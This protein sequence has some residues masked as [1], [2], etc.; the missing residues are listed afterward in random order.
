MDRFRFNKT[1]AS[2]FFRF[3]TSLQRSEKKLQNSQ[4]LTEETKNWIDS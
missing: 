3:H 4:H 2:P 1:T